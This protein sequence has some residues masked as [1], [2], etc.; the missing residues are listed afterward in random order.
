MDIFDV[1][2]RVAMVTWGELLVVAIGIY[3]LQTCMVSMGRFDVIYRVAMVSLG[4]VLLV[5]MVTW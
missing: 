1:I 3:E 2:C 4:V 5:A